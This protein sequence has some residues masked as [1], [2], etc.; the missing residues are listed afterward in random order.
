[1]ENFFR[2]YL[3]CPHCHSEL[4]F[5]DSSL[6]CTS[7]KRSYPMEGSVPNM[8]KPDDAIN[9]EF[10][11][12]NHYI[13]DSETFD[14]FEARTGATEHSERRLREVIGRF[15]P[16][17]VKT[18]LDVGCGSAW[19]AKTFL[20]NG[21]TVCS[22]DAS[23]INP[24]KALQRVPGSKHYGIAADAFHL[25]FK[26]NSIECIIAAEI[27][28]HVPDP[29]AF[30]GELFRILAP[31]GSLIISTPYKEVLRYELCIHCNKQTPVN[32]HLHSFDEQKLASL[33]QSTDLEVFRFRAFNNKLLLFA[34]TYILLR[35]F[36]LKLWM[37]VDKLANLAINK[38]VNI[39]VAYSK[40]AR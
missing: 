22:L 34:R 29:A 17:K 7:C 6:T 11:Y 1:M 21:V 33:N 37:L 5:S 16:S 31:G 38:P 39:V 26:D 20:P 27:I 18:I 8:V 30:V 2:E 40:K 24:H 4:S 28:E 23:T 32:A 14:Y 25:P 35:H 19:V 13:T 12:L 3:V 9:A 15:V 10:D 36:S